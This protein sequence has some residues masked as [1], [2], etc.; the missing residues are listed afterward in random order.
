MYYF[1]PLGH[2]H[3]TPSTQWSGTPGKK[4]Q[5]LSWLFVFFPTLLI[6]NYSD[7]ISH[8]SEK[9]CWFFLLFHFLAMLKQQSLGHKKAWKYQQFVQEHA[10]YS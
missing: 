2:G 1:P 3:A 7:K 8:Y 6:Y 5:W 4:Q 9:S 10:E